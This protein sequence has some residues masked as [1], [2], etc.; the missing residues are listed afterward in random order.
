MSTRKRSTF[1]MQWNGSIEYL[2]K[3]TMSMKEI[4]KKILLAVDGS[5][6]SFNVVR[7]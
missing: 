3:E 2:R 6:R 4:R 1:E 5:D 7:Y